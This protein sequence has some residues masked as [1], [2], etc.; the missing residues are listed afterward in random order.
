V[1]VPVRVGV[2]KASLDAVRAAFN[3]VKIGM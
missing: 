2:H 1:R 3:E